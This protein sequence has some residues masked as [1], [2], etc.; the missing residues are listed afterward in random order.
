MPTKI[1]LADDN[2]TIEKVITLTFANQDV[3]LEAVTRGENALEKVRSY[4]PDIVLADVALPGLSGYDLS[5]Q[6]KEDPQ[7][8]HVPVVLLIGT[9]EEFDE[10]RA[11]QARSDA[12]LAKPF[13]TQELIHTVSSLVG[14]DLGQDPSEEGMPINRSSNAGAAPSPLVSPRTRESFLGSERVLDLFESTQGVAGAD[15]QS[16]ANRA[17][18]AFD[19]HS[20][21]S[22][23]QAAAAPPPGMGSH[24]IPFPGAKDTVDS[25]Q[26]QLDDEILDQIAARVLEKT[27]RDVVRE[28]AWEVVP[29]MAESILRQYLED[30]VPEKS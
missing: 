21:R 28:V 15:L 30:K 29:E 23:S 3:Q 11:H 16:A 22:A 17:G 9:F 18:L 13:D 10:N 27:S 24:V 19:P 20:E 7:H 1:L 5:A 25:I 12:Q 4:C 26:V 8:C 2:V 6:I 14:T